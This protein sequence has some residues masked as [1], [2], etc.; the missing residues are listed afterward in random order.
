MYFLKKLYCE[1]FLGEIPNYFDLLDSKG[2]GGGS[3]FE[4][5]G[6]CRGPNVVRAPM[7][8]PHHE[9]VTIPSI[10]KEHVEAST[11]GTI[12]ALTQTLIHCMSPLVEGEP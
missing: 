10:V 4:R 11:L 6:P 12:N 2:R 9:H 5:S 8:K 7:V 1:F 3:S